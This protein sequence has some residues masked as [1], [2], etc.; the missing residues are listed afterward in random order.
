MSFTTT[1]TTDEIEL[2]IRLLKSELGET[3][4]ELHHTQSPDYRD[5]VRHEVKS[6]R[7]LLV[8][9]EKAMSKM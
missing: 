7:A 2:L 6:V 5:E 1:L 8:K 9:L 4:V 3:R